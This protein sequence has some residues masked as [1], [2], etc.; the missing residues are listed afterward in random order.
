LLVWR[1]LFEQLGVFPDHV[2]SGGD[3]IWTH[4]ATSRGCRLVF[5]SDAEVHKPARKL[6]SMLRKQYRLGFAQPEN[7]RR[8][9][10][11]PSLLHT[12]NV[13]GF[14]PLHPG[15]IHCR[16]IRRGN[17]A[18]MERFPTIW[19]LVW[20]R[21]IVQGLGRI[22]RVVRI[23]MHREVATFKESGT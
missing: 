15:D 4:G 11:S 3:T 7:W 22:H 18:M 9:D 19:L 14:L 6:V 16:I 8:F 17:L 20:L 12:L 23:I 2:R 21:N 10:M 5:A 13:R 1:R